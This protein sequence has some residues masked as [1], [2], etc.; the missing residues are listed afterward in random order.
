MQWGPLL[1]WPPVFA[2]NTNATSAKDRSKDITTA[3]VVFTRRMQAKRPQ[4]VSAPTPL[5]TLELPATL[6]LR[7]DFPLP[8]EADATT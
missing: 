4:Q 8:R 6:A 7:W 5:R 2:V 1:E 3:P